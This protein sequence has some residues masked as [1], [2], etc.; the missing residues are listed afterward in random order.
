MIELTKILMDSV[1]THHGT[2]QRSVTR[3]MALKRGNVHIGHK[4]EL[5]AGLWMSPAFL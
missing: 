1:G 2:L 4:P 3:G 5:K